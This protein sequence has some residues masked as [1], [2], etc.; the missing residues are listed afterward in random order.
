MRDKFQGFD[1]LASIGDIAIPA[2]SAF[3]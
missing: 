2:P 3:R 1:L